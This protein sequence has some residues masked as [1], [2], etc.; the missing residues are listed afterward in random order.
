MVILRQ[1]NRSLNIVLQLADISRPLVFDQRLQRFR[2]DPG[3]VPSVGL[4]IDNV[5]FG[6]VTMAPT[7]SALPGFSDIL[8]KFTAIKATADSAALVGMD[9]VLEASVRD[10]VIEVNNGTTWPGDLGPPDRSAVLQARV[11]DP[12][13]HQGQDPRAFRPAER[14][15]PD[16]PT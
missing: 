3:D 13:P 6:Y 15:Q 7:L 9:E 10:I 5:D 14:A 1:D 11:E 8:P 12:D 4:A 16:A 2:V